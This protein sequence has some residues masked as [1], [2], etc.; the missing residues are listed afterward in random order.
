ML[1]GLLENWYY[2]L[3]S[4]MF[5][6]VLGNCY[7][8]DRPLHSCDTHSAVGSRLPTV[9]ACR[10]RSCMTSKM[11]ASSLPLLLV[12]GGQLVLGCSV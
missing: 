7:G 1:T 11:Y 2:V 12:Q 4:Y 3:A 8:L 6:V 9:Q 10:F 5:K